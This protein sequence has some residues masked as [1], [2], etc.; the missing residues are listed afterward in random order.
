MYTWGQYGTEQTL[1]EM[2]CHCHDGNDLGETIR[3]VQ[4]T[5]LQSR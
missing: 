4:P 1:G 5:V 3:K 2:T